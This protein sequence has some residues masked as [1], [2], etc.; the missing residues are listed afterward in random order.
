M[1]CCFSMQM[2]RTNIGNAVTNNLFERI[3]ITQRQFNVGNQ[4]LYVGVVLLEI[5]SNL[6]MYHVGPRWWL[7]GQVIAW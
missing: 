5:P 3:N 2:D 1:L 6:V 7:G 4:L